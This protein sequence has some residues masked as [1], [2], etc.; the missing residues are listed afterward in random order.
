MVYE[1]GIIHMNDTPES[2]YALPAEAK[3]FLKQVP[4]AWDESR[5]IAAIPGELFVVARRKGAKWFVAGINGK[6][7][8][9]EIQINLPANLESPTFIGD[10]ELPADLSAS[11]M[12][13]SDSSFSITMMPYGGFVLY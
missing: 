8:K 6:N 10:G 3:D 2:Y 12:P 11:K 4:A 1:N 9:K 13:G 5:L 7:E